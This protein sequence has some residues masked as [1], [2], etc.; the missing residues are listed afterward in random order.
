MGNAD[1]VYLCRAYPGLGKSAPAQAADRLSMGAAGNFGH[2]AAVQ[3]MNV[4][5]G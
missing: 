4:N 5:L 2:D 1:K 3:L